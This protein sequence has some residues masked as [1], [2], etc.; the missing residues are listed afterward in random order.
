MKKTV[1]VVFWTKEVWNT[2]INEQNATFHSTP[3]CFP[4]PLAAQTLMICKHFWT[5]FWLS[6]AFSAFKVTPLHGL[7]CIPEPWNRSLRSIQIKCILAEDQGE[8]GIWGCRDCQ[9][10]L[11]V[12]TWPLSVESPRKE[13]GR[14]HADSRIFTPDGAKL[15]SLT[16]NSSR[17]GTILQCNV[18]PCIAA[19]SGRQWQKPW[20]TELTPK[21]QADPPIASETPHPH[22]WLQKDETTENSSDFKISDF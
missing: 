14:R 17:Q 15:L 2:Q 9:V 8:V 7:Q 11:P 21:Q 6:L 1:L 3:D 20:R 13:G 18:I 5:R 12:L 19:D 10:P 16:V 4:S 22:I